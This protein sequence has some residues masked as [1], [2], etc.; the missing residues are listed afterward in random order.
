[1]PNE[2]RL[3]PF[4]NLPHPPLPQAAYQID[5]EPDAADYAD[6]VAWE[7]DWKAWRDRAVQRDKEEHFRRMKRKGDDIYHYVGRLV[8]P[9]RWD[10]PQD[11]EMRLHETV[12]RF[13]D[14]PVRVVSTRDGECCVQFIGQREDV[15]KH[16]LEKTKEN[17]T[18]FVHSSDEDLDVTSIPL[19]YVNLTNQTYYLCRKPMRRQ[20]QGVHPDNLTFLDADKDRARKRYSTR[21]VLFSKG[22][23]QCVSNRYPTVIECLEKFRIEGELESIA[24]NRKMCLERSEDDLGMIW[25]KHMTRTVGFIIPGTQEVQIPKKAHRDA[26]WIKEYLGRTGLDVRFGL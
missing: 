6:P 12:V 2:F 5:E 24:F 21:D 8:D 26:L 1:M 20:K 17:M 11:V 19:G 4:G 16:I 3:D 10:R 23:V 15:P 22:L 13:M 7:R 14:Y 18:F 25:L 9:I